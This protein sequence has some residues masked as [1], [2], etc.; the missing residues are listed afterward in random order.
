MRLGPVPRKVGRVIKD[1]KSVD[2]AGRSKKKGCREFGR[3]IVESSVYEI[4]IIVIT[5]IALFM[6]D[7]ET[8]ILTSTFRDGGQQHGW[9]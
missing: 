8:L 5:F 1:K 9:P 7:V 2:K 4:A 3:R 6:E